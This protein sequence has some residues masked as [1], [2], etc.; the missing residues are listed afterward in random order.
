ME[1]K[2]T[3]PWKSIRT[4][5]AII[6][7][8]L[9]YAYGVQVTHVSLAELRSEQRVASLVRVLR[10]L[11]HPDI[12][13]YDQKE[14]AINVPVYVPCPQ[15]RTLP[16]VS[17]PET[18]G[19]YM[20]VSP[21]CGNPG[22]FVQVEGFNFAAEAQGPLRFV[23]GSDPNNVVT[24]GRDNIETDASGHFVAQFK[25]ANRLSEDVQYIRAT[26]RQNVGNPHFTQTAY[27]TWDKI[28]ETVFLA[29]LATTVGTFL[30]VPLS[31]IAAR[32]LMKPMRSSLTSASLSVLGWPLGI[33]AGFRVVTWI[34]EVSA[35]AAA[36]VP[37]ALVS[38]VA[39]PIVLVFALRWALPE[40]ETK[41]P[42]A[43]L[44]MARLATLFAAAILAFYG[45]FALAG[46]MATVGDQLANI[47]GAFSFL[48]NFLFQ[49][50]DILR[51][52]VP[53]LGA[54]GAGG[55][56][57]GFLGGLGLH[58]TEGLQP[59]LVKLLNILTAMAAGAAVMALLGEAVEW[60]YEIGQPLFTL[61]GPA[62]FGAAVGLA[63]AL[64]TKAK[65]TLAVGM[66]IYYVTRTALNALRAIEPLVMAIVFVITVGIGPFAGAL[67]LGLH[68][69]VSLAKLYSEQV[70]SIAAG[71]QEAIQATGASRLQ[72]IIYA[73]V[74]QIIPP[75]ISYTM[76]RWDVNVRMST[77]IGFVGGGGIGFLL[78]QNINLLNYRAASAQILAI[79][80]VVASLDYV[81]SA[82]RERFV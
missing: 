23:P 65:D 80:I 19:P 11:A 8:L 40:V 10:A 1:K 5:L 6:V 26:T 37:A 69:V 3:S 16:S 74:P 55:A 44:K 17:S 82:I 41:K 39:V 52:I 4:G 18:V 33:Y 68:T 61:W 24:L 45:L 22:D 77:I 21:A 30:A 76:Y 79:A 49:M 28:I 9:V 13:A 71:P 2:K 7:I 12:V 31:F 46:L 35:A 25:L 64:R 36:S 29:L 34:G 75:Y 81:S 32:N 43:G 58:A 53:V 66:V 59:G 20:I 50:G 78:Q 63:A 15:A 47:M 73:V 48:G 72:T 67:A 57:S 38:I 51:I 27:D 70:E 14:V 56:L 42:G 54:L 62:T 60:F